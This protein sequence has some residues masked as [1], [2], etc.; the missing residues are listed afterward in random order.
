MFFSYARIVCIIVKIITF[1]F[2]YAFYNNYGNF[3]L[4]TIYDYF[5]LEMK[6]FRDL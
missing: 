5:L 1:S 3:I 2:V 6:I 4:Y